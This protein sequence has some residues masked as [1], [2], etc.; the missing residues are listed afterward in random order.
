[1]R[2]SSSTPVCCD[3]V[4]QSECPCLTLPCCTCLTTCARR[5]RQ[6]QLYSHRSLRPLRII[7]G[8]FYS[9][10]TVPILDSPP[11][12]SAVYIRH[13]IFLLSP[14][15]SSTW[16]FQLSYITM[17]SL[18]LLS[19]TEHEALSKRL[20]ILQSFVLSSFGVFSRKPT[21]EKQ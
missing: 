3:N 18:L 2:R 11:L 6:H 8:H 9:P 20:A 19:Q 12:E 16:S 7:H 15:L 13:F 1:M 4:S 10:N 17:V 14:Y 5:P 21:S